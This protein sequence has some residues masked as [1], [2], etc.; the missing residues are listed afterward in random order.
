MR[1]QPQLVQLVPKLSL[2]VDGVAD[3][4]ATLGEALQS[5]EQIPSWFLGG[6]PLD[7]LARAGWR[8]C[9]GRIERR[10]A[11]GLLAALEDIAGRQ[12][13][14]NDM[15]VL[16][17]YV[18]YGFATR[19]CPFWLVSG[20]GRWKRRNQ[21]ARLI[22]MFHELYAFGPPWRSSFW[23]SP[24]QRYLARRLWH[25]SDSAVTNVERYRRQLCR[26]LPASEK[27]VSLMPVFSSVGETGGLTAWSARPA[28]LVVYG[29]PGAANRAYGPLR[30]QLLL[31]CERLQI[32]EI[33]DIGSRATPP[34]ARIGSIPVSPR[35]HLP[36][37]S[38]GAVLGTAK[39][40][41][42]DYPSD[43]LG[44]STVFAAYA[45]HGLVPVVSWCRGEDEP[46]LAEGVNYWVPS[47]N[48][49]R[50]LDFESIAAKASAWYSDHRLDIQVRE[51]ARKLRGTAS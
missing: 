21:R 43:L 33:V 41:F 22:T 36:S 19:G 5:G 8:E 39:A 48:N 44:K 11:D 4:A 1:E 13:G 29:R 28:R 7:A 25:M 51:Y 2:L 30:D 17:H 40:G 24:V 23:L 32:E 46:G 12:S 38:I 37:S 14:G 42:I 16:L 18:N 31:A 26:W 34:P 15:V 35:G 27:K 47:P 9:S 20:L 49:Q 6:D 10:S 45:T 50:S 3:Y